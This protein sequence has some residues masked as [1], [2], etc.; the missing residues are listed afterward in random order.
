[1]LYQYKIPELKCIDSTGTKGYVPDEF[2]LYPV[3]CNTQ[4]D[5]LYIW[6]Y[7]PFEIREFDINNFKLQQKRRLFLE[8]YES[9]NQMHIIK[10][11]ILIYSAIPDEFAIKKYDLINKK[12]LGKIKIKRD[13]HKETYFYKNRGWVA[14]NDSCIIYAYVY[15]KQIDIYS[16]NKLNL[17]S[18]I[19]SNIP[20]NDIV[21]GDIENN[22][23]HYINI[24]AGGKYFY[25]LYM[26]FSRSNPKSYY[27]L[28]KYDYNGNPIAKYKLDIAPILF[29]ID[30]EN[31]YM[32]GYNFQHEDFI[33]KYNLSL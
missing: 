20:K 5:N 9:F 22:V 2:Q 26:G 33:I 6:G 13:R 27:T 21:I 19:V 1:M 4:T 28:E 31:N 24:V 15:K 10:D 32:Y 23:K 8:E 11:S 14:A 16:V 29:D 30:E 17:K 18:K 12:Q 3:F 7:T 25:A